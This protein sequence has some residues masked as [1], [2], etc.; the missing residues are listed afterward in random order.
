MRFRNLDINLLVVLHYLLQGKSVNE[1]AQLLG[2]T[3]PAVSNALARLRDYFEEPLFLT[4]GRRLEP[5]PFAKSLAA[6]VANA[7]EEIERVICARSDFVPQTAERTFTIICSDYVHSVFVTKLVRQLAQSAPRVRLVVLLLSNI[8][9]T[10]LEEGKADFLIA[11]SPL[12]FPGH[13]RLPLF[14]ETYSCIAWEGN[15]DIGDSLSREAYLNA[16]HVDVAL[17][18][19]SP[20]LFET[21]EEPTKDD[22]PP[23]AHIFAPTFAAVADT[24]V[25]T[26][27]L[28]TVHTRL[29]N[30]F[31]ERLPLRVLELPV[32][33]P[34]IFECLQWHR[35]KDAD[36]GTIWLKDL[37]IAIAAE[38]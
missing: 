29:A 20:K 36:L 37:M 15:D 24:V 8:G 9:V 13:P 38:L 21:V 33:S 12:T 32:T 34:H 6:S 4:L 5:T 10:F 30:L 35:N 26:H 22:K 27:Y 3:Q 14:D 19:N 2:L 7:Y 23:I 31:A 28:A 1:T 11:P 17:G 25:G 18:L 16:R